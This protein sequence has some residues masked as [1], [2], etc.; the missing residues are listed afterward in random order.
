M[1]T[2]AMSSSE[3]LCFEKKLAAECDH[4][5]QGIV[6]K[7]PERL[8][9]RFRYSFQACELK[10]QPNCSDAL[11]IAEKLGGE[12]AKK[13]ENKVK[14]F[15]DQEQEGCD[16]LAGIYDENGQHKKALEFSF[17]HW[18][19]HHDGHY[20]FFEYQY[21]DKNKAYKIM[22]E[23]CEKNND[24]CQYIFRYYP[25]HPQRKKIVEYAQKAC[26]SESQ[27][28]TGASVCI[29]LGIYFYDLNEKAKG[30]EFLDMNCKTNSTACE[31]LVAIEDTLEKKEQAFKKF[32]LALSK[33]TAIHIQS[34]NRFCKD[35]K[36]QKIN[37]EIT[38]SSQDLLNSWRKN[39]RS[40]NL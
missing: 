22:F 7:T 4:H 37:A 1:V 29:D 11:M 13:I 33:Q 20:P 32:C 39:I 28:N 8:K 3:E 26:R 36:L 40:K 15:C 9:E 30:L 14:E 23:S 19:K 38:K 27:E 10:F 18:Q 17:K 5:A 25:E 16:T 21:G 24:E 6:E 2:Q 34:T 31:V 12:F 35:E